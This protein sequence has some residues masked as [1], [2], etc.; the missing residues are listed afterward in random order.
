MFFITANA[1]NQYVHSRAMEKIY[2][3]NKNAHSWLMEEPTQDC[4]RFMFDQ[5]LKVSDN[6]TDFVESFNGKIERFRHKPIMVLLEAIL[7]TFMSIIAKRAE[8]A[9]EWTESVVPKVTKQLLKLELDS[10]TCRVTPAGMGEFL[11][12]DDFT[13]NLNTS[14]YDCIF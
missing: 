3:E 8:I 14:H 10:K 1:Y 12:Q 9:K 6:T 2:K 7:H 4:A 11:V 5:E 13:I